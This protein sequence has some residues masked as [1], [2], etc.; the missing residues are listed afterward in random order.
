MERGDTELHFFIACEPLC[1]CAG[2]V[3]HGYSDRQLERSTGKRSTGIEE[4]GNSCKRAG[5]D[6]SRMDTSA[7]NISSVNGCYFTP[8]L[9]LSFLP[10]DKNQEPL[11]WSRL[12]VTSDHLGCMCVHMCALNFYRTNVFRYKLQCC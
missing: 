6:I 11:P 1:L 3:Y 8:Q 10:F 12:P 5:G 2:F 4:N 9:P 7:A